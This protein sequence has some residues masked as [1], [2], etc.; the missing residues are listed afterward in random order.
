MLA[1]PFDGVPP[2]L[3]LRGLLKAVPSNESHDILWGCV[4]FVLLVNRGLGMS[5]GAG[6]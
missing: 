2:P 6:S 3:Y 1:T 5:W 4:K